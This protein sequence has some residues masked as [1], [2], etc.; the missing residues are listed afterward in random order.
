VWDTI[1][2]YQQS[3][4]C[5]TAKKN[6]SIESIETIESVAADSMVGISSRELT[7]VLERVGIAKDN[8]TQ[9]APVSSIQGNIL[10]IHTSLERYIH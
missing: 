7:S 4:Y 9:V 8:V 1:S 6:A 5:G 10:D 3:A 2:A